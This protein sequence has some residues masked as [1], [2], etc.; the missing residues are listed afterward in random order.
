M[1]K[2]LFG[3]GCFWGVEDFFRQVPGV[4]EAVSGYAGGTTQDPTYRQVCG[5]DTY[6]AEDADYAAQIHY[7]T[8][9]IEQCLDGRT[10]VTCTNYGD[11]TTAWTEVKG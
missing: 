11:W 9:P 2:A 4:S 8:T 10:D 1:E 6:H 5:G 7:W 3:A